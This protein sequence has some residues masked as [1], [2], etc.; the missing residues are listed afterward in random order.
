MANIT[1]KT[2]LTASYLLTTLILMFVMYW[3]SNNWDKIQSIFLV[4][5]IFL[6]LLF[7]L[8]V[9]TSINVG[10][11]NQLIVSHLGYPLKPIQWVSLAFASTLANYIFPMR[12]GMALRATYFKKCHGFSLSKFASSMAF[13]YVITFIANAFL[14]LLLMFWLG[15]EK[16]AVNWILIL[17]FAIVLTT[18][19]AALM[20]NPPIDKTVSKFKI[21]KYII[22]IHG[23]M[24]LLR[25]NPK[26]LIR[27]CLLILFNTILF[28]IRLFVSFHALGHNIN[29]AGCLLVGCF[30]AVSMFISITPASL[31]IKEVAIVFAS[32]VIGVSPEISFL[33][34]TLDRT[35][36]MVVIAIFGTAG[37]IKISHETAR[38]SKT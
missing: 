24:E 1:K 22:S 28:G 6:I 20:Y 23:G 17:I 3:V 37:M 30:A 4:E 38:I 35:V 10:L 18:G 21:F 5:P 16:N 31:G 33:A 36:S 2:K 34:A 13:A 19:I 12:A 29:L 7:P 14:G 25:K 9:F 15:I 27:C 11:I 32:S 8:V 26:L